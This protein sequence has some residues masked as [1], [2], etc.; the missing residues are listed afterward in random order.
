[1]D[2]N[3]EQAVTPDCHTLMR[4]HLIWARCPRQI[5]NA[6]ASMDTR[7]GLQQMGGLDTRIKRIGVRSRLV[8]KEDN[9]MSSL[10]F[11]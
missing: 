3:E 8:E 9:R 11:L 7:G 10:D 2:R 5:I 6:L 1:M 4:D